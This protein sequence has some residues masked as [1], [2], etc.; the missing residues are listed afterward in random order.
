MSG[1]SSAVDTATVQ[2]FRENVLAKLLDGYSPDDVYNCDETAFFFKCLPD[3]TL[4]YK[5]EE[6]P[7]GK[8]SKERITMLL[9]CNWS[10]M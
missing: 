4:A 10:G 5:S 2:D 1:E 7:G 8:M 9:T 3:K 6:C